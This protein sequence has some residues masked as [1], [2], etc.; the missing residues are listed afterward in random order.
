MTPK[1]LEICGRL[2]F[3]SWNWK[4]ELAKAISVD[5]M[6]IYRWADGDY[7]IPAERKEQVIALLE[8]RFK[9]LEGALYQIKGFKK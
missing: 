9:D 6:T 3:P 1:Q 8:R 2:L 4:S 7:K 5:R